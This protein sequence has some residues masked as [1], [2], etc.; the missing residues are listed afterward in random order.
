MISNDEKKLI[1]ETFVE[2]LPVLRAAIGASQADVASAI[3]IS[4]Q[5]YCALEQKKRSTSWNTFLSLFLFFG[6]NEKSQKIMLAKKDFIPTVKRSL[7]VDT[8]NKN[9]LSL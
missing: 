5:T 1:A 4:R 9:E 6:T 7:I 2:T 3:G 8:E